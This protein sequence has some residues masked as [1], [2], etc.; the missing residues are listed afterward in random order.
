MKILVLDDA[1]VTRSM[2]KLTLESD[3]RFEVDMA[4]NAEEA[5]SFA[6]QTHYDLMIID[7][8]IGKSGNGLDFIQQLRESAVNPANNQKTICIMLSAEESSC[9]KKRAMQLGIKAWV[10]KP[11]SPRGLIETLTTILELDD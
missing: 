7:F 9:C 4:A 5:Y 11:F 10:K 1:A 3:K 6:M 2:V 8:M